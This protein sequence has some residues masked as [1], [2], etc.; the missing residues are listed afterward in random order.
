MVVVIGSSVLAMHPTHFLVGQ[1]GSWFADHFYLVL[2]CFLSP[3]LPGELVCLLAQQRIN[4][5]ELQEDHITL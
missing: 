1:G 4:W 2:N 3:F 5:K